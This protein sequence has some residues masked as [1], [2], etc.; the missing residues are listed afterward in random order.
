MKQFSLFPVARGIV[1]IIHRQYILYPHRQRSNTYTLKKN[2]TYNGQGELILNSR[3]TVNL[4]K[5]HT[6]CKNQ[7]YKYCER[8]KT[9]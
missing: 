1:A 6:G 4:R 7:V 3:Q 2:N 5:T 8:N 9:E